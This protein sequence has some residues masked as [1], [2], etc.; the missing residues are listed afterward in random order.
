MFD[1]GLSSTGAVPASANTN[2]T[3]CPE[4]IANKVYQGNQRGGLHIGYPPFAVWEHYGGT[5]GPQTPTNA[6]DNQ[7]PHH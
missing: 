6:N 3:A 5:C 2:S 4:P 1:E 7:L